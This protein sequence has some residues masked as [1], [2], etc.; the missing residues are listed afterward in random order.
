M[1]PELTSVRSPH[2]VLRMGALLIA[3]LMVFVGCAGRVPPPDPFDAASS[4]IGLELKMRTPIKIT[5][6]KPNLVLFVRLEEGEGVDDVL[7]KTEVIPS[8]FCDGEQAYLLNAE[9]GTYVAVAAVYGKTRNFSASSTSQVGGGTVTM[10]TSLRGKETNRNYFSRELVEATL[11]PVPAGSFAFMGRYVTD[12]SGS[13]GEGDE[14]Q[15]YFL[16]VVEGE[17]AQKSGFAKMLSGDYSH[18]LDIHEIER[19][20][21]AEQQFLEKARYHLGETAWLARLDPAG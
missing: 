2:A 8:T 6:K 13:F 10:N 21:E 19:G 7:K 4:A 12:Q 16:W 15:R 20:P 17:G 1:T 11:T 5:S 3:T 9:P 18:R 14:M